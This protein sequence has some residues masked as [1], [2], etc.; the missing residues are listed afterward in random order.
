MTSADL[1]IVAIWLATI[2]L[3]VW[4]AWEPWRRTR[5][6]IGLEVPGDES[7]RVRGP[8]FVFAP[9]VVLA[10]APFAAQLARR[11][12]VNVWLHPHLLMPIGLFVLAGFVGVQLTLRQT[13]LRLAE[14][15]A[16]EREQRRALFDR[17]G[18]KRARRP[19]I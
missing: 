1:L 2:A 3:M 13:F 7:G 9:A 10:A 16:V 5:R 18:P 11:P 4:L 6:M 19:P 14:Q 15:R 17:G 8:M 12:G